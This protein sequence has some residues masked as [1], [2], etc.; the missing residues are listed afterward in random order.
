MGEAR[1]GAVPAFGAPDR[2]AHEAEIRWLT[3]RF[4]REDL[5]QEFRRDYAARFLPQHRAGLLLGLLL[6]AAFGALD[7]YVIP[8]AARFAWYVRYAAICPLLLLALVL[9]RAPW[10]A[11]AAQP[12]LAGVGF[13]AGVGII[14]MI[15]RSVPPGR[16]LYY[17]GLMLVCAYVH[18][19]FR[20]RFLAAAASAW[21]MAALYELAIRAWGSPVPAPVHLSS[22]VFL[23]AIN[24]IGMSACYA[25]ERSARVDFLQRRVIQD[26][27]A[28]LR[29]ALAQVRTLTGLL[30]MC[31]WCKKIRDDGGY[32][33]QLEE[34]LAA[35]SDAVFSHGICPECAEGLRDEGRLLPVTARGE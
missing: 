27:A 11:R 9:S 14:G 1:A 25:M 28:E 10:F 13:L 16:H 17:A 6:Y 7:P 32:W 15:I 8:E 26:Q 5:E 31:A 33:N 22:T 35:H 18:T 2:R 29:Q 20:L 30:P 12:V 19:F 4:S 23:G 34:Y 3:L 24:V 21:G